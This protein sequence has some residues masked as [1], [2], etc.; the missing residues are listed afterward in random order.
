M[1]PLASLYALSVA[2]GLFTANTYAGVG[3]IFTPPME[4]L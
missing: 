1:P 3:V 2:K 4:G